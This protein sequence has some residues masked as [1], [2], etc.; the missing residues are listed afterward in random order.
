VNTVLW[1]LQIALCLKSVS[2][3]YTHAFRTDQAKWQQGMQRF[4]AAARPLLALIALLAFLGGVG[5]ILPAATGTLTWLTPLTAALLALMMLLAVRFHV[6]CRETPNIVV[7]LVLF[8]LAAFV[9]Y[10]RWVI[11]PF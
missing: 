10:G 5:L 1:I 2:V 6:A 3:A 7:G 11:A 8:A 9:S 4:G